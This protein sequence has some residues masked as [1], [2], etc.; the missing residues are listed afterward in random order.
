MQNRRLGWFAVLALSA[1]SQVPTNNTSDPTANF[2]QVSSG[3]FRGARP[4]Q[5]A[6]TQLSQMGVHSILN[7]EDDTQAVADEKTWTDALKM[8]QYSFPMTG[9]SSPDNAEVSQALSVLAD[10][11]QYPIFVHCM[12]GQDRTGVVIALHRVFNEGW[13]ANDASQEMLDHGFNTT[14]VAL[15]D[16]FNQKVGF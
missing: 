15:H 11:K 3:I 10:S 1:C 7:L 8:T 4:D 5:A 6:V 14:L 13:S 16:Y 9:T 2:S 12:K